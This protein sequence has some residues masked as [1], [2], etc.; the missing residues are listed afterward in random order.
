MKCHSIKI[1]H[2]QTALIDAVTNPKDLL[3]QLEL[4]PA[5]LPAAE[6][7]AKIFPLKI[8]HSFIARMQ[9]GDIN[10]PLLKQV[11]PINAELT[12]TPGYT[13]DPLQEAQFNPIPGLLHKYHGRVLLTLTG[14]CAINCRYCFRRDFD[15]GE[16]NP[17]SLGWLKAV[18]YIAK[19]S[20]I[21]EVILS[22]GDPLVANDQTL[23]NLTAKLAAIPHVK[24]LRIHS[25]IPVV[26]PERI[27]P[28][29]IDAVT[30]PSLK[31]IMVV[32]CNHP[33]EINQ[34]VRLAISALKQAGIVMLNQTVLLKGINDQ[35]DVLVA[36]SESLF[37][38]GI[39]PYYLHVLDKVQ[40]TAH[41]DLERDHACKLH[42][43]MAQRLSGYLVP[44]LVC[45][46]PGAPAKI[47]IN[48]EEFYT[49]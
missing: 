23:Q 46:Q 27:T 30:A 7:A 20:T 18:N 14:A 43:G 48:P 24:R 25:R 2:W 9:K 26:L 32:H 22:G 15:Y 17:G 47:S 34:E 42:W 13:T 5:L 39:Q 38:V 16:N 28:E 44:K 29:F 21:S 41:F 31:T 3:E 36:L 11:L 6:A 33:N 12:E 4:D 40:G 8:P 45:E 35:V 37:D 49:D 1:N 19:N 10:D